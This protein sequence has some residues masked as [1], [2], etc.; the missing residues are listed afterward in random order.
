MEP[1]EQTFLNLYPSVCM[2]A[3]CWLTLD[4]QRIPK[5]PVSSCFIVAHPHQMYN[6][7]A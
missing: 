2:K 7:N 5:H 6:Y 1:V 3:S 4:S